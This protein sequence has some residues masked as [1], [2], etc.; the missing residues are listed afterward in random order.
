MIADTVSA[1]ADMN[2]LLLSAR[3]CPAGQDFTRHLQVKAFI[4]VQL[5]ETGLGGRC[6][7]TRTEL[8]LEVAKQSLKKSYV[9][10][11]I[12]LHETSWITKR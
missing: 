2:K 7:K 3:K 12:R 8:S 11:R 4:C 5:A 10:K 9:A 6:A 1:L